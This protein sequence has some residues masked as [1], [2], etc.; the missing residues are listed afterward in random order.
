MTW[1][2]KITPVFAQAEFVVASWEFYLS[3]HSQLIQR[4][5]SIILNEHLSSEDVQ[6][7]VR[8]QGLRE[9]VVN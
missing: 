5:N 7:K 4:D 3:E 1:V 9:Q 6:G 2:F 8:M